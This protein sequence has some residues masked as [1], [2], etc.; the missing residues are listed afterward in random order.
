MEIGNEDKVWVSVGGKINMEP[1][2]GVKYENLDI[3]MGQSRTVM[4]G[5]SHD[6][7][8]MD[9]VH[10]ILSDYLDLE[11]EIKD[12]PPSGRREKEEKEVSVLQ[13]CRGKR[14]SMPQR[15]RRTRA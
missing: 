15:G 9:M 13:R 8:R 10:K 14:V 6:K 4:E 7:V 1:I 5:E 11:A 3:Q 12:K 2:T